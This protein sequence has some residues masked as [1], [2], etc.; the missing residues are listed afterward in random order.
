M[1][2]QLRGFEFR[3]GKP[4]QIHISDCYEISTRSLE[5][6]MADNLDTSDA[7]A[8]LLETAQFNSKLRGF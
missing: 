2:I 1:V 7:C 6:V 4:L 5:V 8:Q 3:L